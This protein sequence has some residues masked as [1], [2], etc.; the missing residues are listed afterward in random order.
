[1]AITMWFSLTDF[2]FIRYCHCVKVNGHCIVH[3]GAWIFII[4]RLHK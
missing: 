1:M 2:S 3:C 4:I